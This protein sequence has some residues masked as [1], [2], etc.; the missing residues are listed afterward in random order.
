MLTALHY[1][2][3][4]GEHRH[5]CSSSLL[6]THLP[7]TKDRGMS[8]PGWSQGQPR[9]GWGTQG[10]VGAA[11]LAIPC[12]VTLQMLMFWGSEHMYG[13]VGQ[14]EHIM[15]ICVCV[16]KQGSSCVQR[17][18]PWGLW[19]VGH[20]AGVCPGVPQGLLRCR[21]G[22]WGAAQGARSVCGHSCEYLRLN[23]VPAC[24][25]VRGGRWAVSALR[26]LRRRGRAVVF[27]AN[28][29]LGLVNVFLLSFKHKSRD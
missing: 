22:P 14:H 5:Q 8:S 21:C 10:C 12:P 28:H 3:C 29:S 13:T 1:S 25:W 26:S 27:V 18:M 2:S 11:A 19:G 4:N 9:R 16:R 23:H 20:S 7:S 17:R 24:L 15:Y 6:H